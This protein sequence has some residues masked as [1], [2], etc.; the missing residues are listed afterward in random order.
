GHGEPP[1]HGLEGRSLA[2]RPR[3]RLPGVRPVLEGDAPASLRERRDARRDAADDAQPAL[4]P[5]PARADPRGDRRAAP[6]RAPRGDP[7]AD[8]RQALAVM[9]EDPP[10]HLRL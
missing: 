7:A 10:S 5:P 3:V 1:E 2:A 4:L 8:A 9:R 6:G